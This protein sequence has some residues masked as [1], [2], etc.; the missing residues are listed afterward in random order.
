MSR[1]SFTF[2][3]TTALLLL[4]SNAPAAHASGAPARDDKA[5]E[6]QRARLP[7]EP[8]EEL[9]YEGEFSR[10]LLRGIKI[11][12]FTF[13]SGRAPGAGKTGPAEGANGQTVAVPTSNPAQRQ[14]LFTGDVVS[15]GWFRKLFGINFRYRVE[16]VVEPGSFSVL[17][18]TKL[19]E[20]GKRVR[21]SEAVFDPRE[22]RVTWTERDPNDPSR[23]PRVV[24]STFDGAAHDIITAIY[25][26]RTQTL[27][28]GQRL[29]LN[30]SDSGRVF[31]VPVE[32]LAEKK[33]LKTAVGRVPVVRVEVGVFGPGRLIEDEGRMTIWMTDD[34]RRLPVRARL[35]SGYG[36]IDIT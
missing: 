30:V 24:N 5:A 7:F 35:S 15:R 29:E 26:L 2:L 20:Q 34:A 32:V 12:E 31:R 17:R 4:S 13:T 33:P 25:F 8:S 21:T 6:A 16:S 22:R 19:D 10:S 28:P 27:A 23:D 18:T 1:R 11:A 3:L 14:F 9:V 36:Q